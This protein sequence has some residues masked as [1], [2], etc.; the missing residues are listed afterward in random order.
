MWFHHSF[1]LSSWVQLLTLP[2]S[3]SRSF[4]YSL[5][6]LFLRISFKTHLL[7]IDDT[8]STIAFSK[9]AQLWSYSLW[10]PPN[11]LLPLSRILLKT[12]EFHFSL[13]NGIWH[14][15]FQ[16]LP[17]TYF[18]NLRHSMPTPSFLA[19]VSAF[20]FFKAF[21]ISSLVIRWW[22]LSKILTLNPDYRHGASCI[23][24]ISAIK[25]SFLY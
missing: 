20:N 16:L 17:H 14:A 24:K 3:W 2:L 15:A 4:Q 22:A 13:V 21:S 23:A 12:S 8:Q 19:V 5:S 6:T 25:I 11:I 7:S 18:P 10:Y 9:D 1:Q